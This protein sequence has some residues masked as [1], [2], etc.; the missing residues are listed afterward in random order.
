M[1]KDSNVID[2]KSK[3][4]LLPFQIRAILMA[5]YSLS[6]ENNHNVEVFLSQLEDKLLSAGAATLVD[7][8]K[9]GVNSLLEAKDEQ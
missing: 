5:Q 9:K 6:K 8:F 4:P 3:K 2:F 7:C 1:T